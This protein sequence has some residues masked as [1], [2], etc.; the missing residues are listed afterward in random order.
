[1]F[2]HYFLQ[3][4]QNEEV[5]KAIQQGKLDAKNKK[6]VAAFKKSVPVKKLEEIDSPPGSDDNIGKQE[7]QQKSGSTALCQWYAKEKLQACQGYFKESIE[8]CKY[9]ISDDS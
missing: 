8:V 6:A 3:R 7:H 9:E 1:M 2:I 5:Q 4:I